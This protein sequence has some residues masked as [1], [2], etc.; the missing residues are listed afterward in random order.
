MRKIFHDE[1]LQKQ[2]DKNG[3]VIVDWLSAFEFSELETVLSDLKSEEKENLKTVESSYK[4]SFFNANASYRSKVLATISSFFKEKTDRFLDHY[5]PLIIN[6]FDKEPGGGEVPVHQNWTFVDESK[7]TSVSIWIPFLD[8]SRENGGLEVVKGSHRVLTPFRS[9]SIP[10]VFNDLFN[11]L[12]EKYLEPLD[13]KKGKAAII[14]D[15]ILH[16]SSGNKTD[17]IRTAI[18]LIMHPAE[19][20]PLHYYRDSQFPEQLEVF[21]VDKK[22]FTSFNMKEK[23]QSVKSCG[24]IPYQYTNLDEEKLLERISIQNP[25]IQTKR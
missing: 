22:F 25:G 15:S 16:W 24:F 14:D 17:K 10:W 19:A 5:V 8:A 20:T 21:E 1:A 11:E 2:F 7:F 9:P 23:P 18:Q 4:L 13:V 6:I 12:R 3:F